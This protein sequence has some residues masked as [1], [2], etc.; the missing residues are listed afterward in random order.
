MAPSNA[1][2]EKTP[3]V[4]LT[5]EAKGKKRR[6]LGKY[7][8]ITIL[9]SA[10]FVSSTSTRPDLYRYFHTIICT[11]H[12]DN[13]WTSFAQKFSKYNLNHN[14]YQWHDRSKL[15]DIN[16]CLDYLVVHETTTNNLLEGYNKRWK[17][18]CIFL[19]LMMP[20]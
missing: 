6:N 3:A 15:V 4:F 12:E 8:R 2:S 20:T 5:S 9:N 16:N 10:V 18:P 17:N 19:S 1:F 13:N 14:Y 7:C 11:K